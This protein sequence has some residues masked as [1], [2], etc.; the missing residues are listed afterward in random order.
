MSPTALSGGQEEEIALTE[1]LNAQYEMSV[2]AVDFLGGE[3][4]RNYRID[5]S[6]GVTFLAKV[7]KDKDLRTLS[8]AGG[9]PC[10]SCQQGRRCLDAY[11][12]S[13]VGRAAAL[14]VLAQSQH[15]HRLSPQ[16]ALGY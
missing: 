12:C 3:V 10:A 2:D 4:D 8:V 1:H 9:D 11:D 6:A 5:T 14:S 16:L 7:Q 15:G 13:D